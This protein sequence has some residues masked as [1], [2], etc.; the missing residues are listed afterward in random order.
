MA[1]VRHK[2]TGPEWAVRRRLWAAG[3]RYRLHVSSLP[4]RPDLLFRAS[5]LAVF[6]HG[7]FWHRHSGCSRT[8]TP[9][10]NVAFWERKF[11]ENQL[12][13][14]RNQMAL[15]SLGWVVEVI[16]EC[17][18]GKESWL[19]RVAR[20]LNRKPTQRPRAGAAQGSQI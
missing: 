14:Q 9:K 19:S 10:S 6:V 4:G 15:E 8:R 17:E 13:D 11:R 7:C 18:V 5:R 2:N 1:L 20:H 16:W 12:R 3:Y